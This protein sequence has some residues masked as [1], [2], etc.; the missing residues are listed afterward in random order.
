[1]ATEK[2]SRKLPGCC[3][4]NAS[5]KCRNCFCVKS[6]RPCS[7]C[8]PSRRG[9]CEN[10]RLL[11]P[12]LLSDA[13]DT[14]DDTGQRNASHDGACPSCSDESPGDELGHALSSSSLADDHVAKVS[15]PPFSPMP[16]VRIFS[17]GVPRIFQRGVRMLGRRSFVC[18]RGLTRNWKRGGR[19]PR[20]AA[21]FSN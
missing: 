16:V 17:R 14:V 19:N 12:A 10:A 7:G 2:R 3:R 9:L 18:P 1:M 13:A 4:C 6:R 20:E 5:G 11:K 15:L 21:K 8:L